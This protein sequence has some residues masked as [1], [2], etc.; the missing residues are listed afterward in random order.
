MPNDEVL[1]AKTTPALKFI[2]KTL[3]GE[4]DE[5]RVWAKDIHSQDELV[6]AYIDE[7]G[8]PTAVFKIHVTE[9]MRNGYGN[10]H[11]GAIS[12]YFDWL[13]SLALAVDPRYYPTDRA[14]ND[15]DYM[16]IV[17]E[18]GISRHLEVRYT[19]PMNVDED[20]LMIVKLISNSSNGCYYEAKIVDDAGK[21]YAA[22]IHDKVKLYKKVQS[23]V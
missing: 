16:Q 18:L 8:T 11:G 14:P 15:S 1:V 6:R 22:G 9:S 13:T 12:T 17:R 2:R 23:K 19:R 4:K 10:A 5:I 20:Y 21:I 3:F 7:E